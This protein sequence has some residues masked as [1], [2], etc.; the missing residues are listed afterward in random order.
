MRS[1]QVLEHVAD[2]RL[3]LDADGHAELLR[4]GLDGMNEILK[5]GFCRAAPPPASRERI[6][7]DAPDATVLLVDF[8][9]AI[10][11]RVHVHRALYCAADLQ[12]AGE[13]G[14]VADLEGTPVDALDTD[15]K[16]VTFHEA[17]VTRDAAGRWSTRL[18]FDL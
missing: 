13:T 14:L 11:T 18:V 5:P 2:V 7:L 16:A 4:A 10:L 17:E 15:I 8:L 1:F 3:R 9:S 6:V 12:L